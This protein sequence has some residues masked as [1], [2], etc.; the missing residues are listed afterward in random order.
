[1]TIE[2]EN[3]MITAT[4]TYKDGTQEEREFPTWSAYGKFIDDH[5]GTIRGADAADLHPA[6][7]R[8]GKEKK[9]NRRPQ[10]GAG[11]R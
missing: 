11:T 4:I 6:R 5:A 7:I 3:D 10:A 8:E 1:M 9:Q 2:R